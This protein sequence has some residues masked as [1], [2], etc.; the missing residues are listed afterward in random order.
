MSAAPTYQTMHS[1]PSEVTLTP[2]EVTLCP[3]EMGLLPPTS[4]QLQRQPKSKV[5]RDKAKK[6]LKGLAD[7]YLDDAH[8]TSMAKAPCVSVEA[9]KHLDKTD[10]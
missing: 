1:A 9:L 10:K 6:V 4:Q 7:S 3:S 5:L 2:S 8:A